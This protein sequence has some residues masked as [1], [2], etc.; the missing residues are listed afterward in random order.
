MEPKG[1]AGGREGV[2][3]WELEG[4]DLL[5]PSSLFFLIHSS[6]HFLHPPL[7]YSHSL[8]LP[9]LI[10]LPFH[11]RVSFG[12]GVTSCLEVEPKVGPTL[13]SR[14]TSWGTPLNTPE[15]L[16]DPEASSCVITSCPLPCRIHF[17]FDISFNFHN[18]TG[19]ST[20]I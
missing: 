3:S 2:Q 16:G 1:T 14:D 17:H 18:K 4:Q 12:E 20:H 10:Y 9:L 6:P 15:S 13:Q 7:L 8:V 19:I 5:I 11:V